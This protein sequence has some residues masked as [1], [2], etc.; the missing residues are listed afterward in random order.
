MPQEILL[1]I[2]TLLTAI[3]GYFVKK[4]LDKTELIAF[5]VSDIKP[6]VD[7][8]WKDKIA[9]SFSPRQLNEQG[10]NILRASGIKEIID[11]KKDDLLKLVKAKKVSNPYDAEESIGAV[12]LELPRYYPD[13]ID[14]IKLGAFNTGANMDTVLFAGSIYLRN[15]IFKDLGFSLDDL[16]QPRKS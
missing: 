10:N 15:L 16:D 14:K 1:T 11:T 8:L 7:I 4:T 2:I 3:I 6:K 12:M 9:P 5:D 13:I